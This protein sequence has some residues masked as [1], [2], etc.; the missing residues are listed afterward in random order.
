MVDFIGAGVPIQG[1]ILF[2]YLTNIAEGLL[3]KRRE[4]LQ[5]SGLAAVAVAV[6]SIAEPAVL[7]NPW[8][9][10]VFFDQEYYCGFGEDY[11]MPIKTETIEAL[12]KNLIASGRRLGKNG[13]LECLT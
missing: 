2:T 6:P 12:R 13:R 1:I 4:F 10:H 5:K 11:Y 3:M 9:N 8:D 7:K